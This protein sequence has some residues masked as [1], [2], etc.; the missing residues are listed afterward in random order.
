[1]HKCVIVCLCR[2]PQSHFTFTKT[3]SFNFGCLKKKK[4]VNEINGIKFMQFLHNF[5]QVL[6]VILNGPMSFW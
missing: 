6:V 2:T 1:M 3:L 5:K 4:S